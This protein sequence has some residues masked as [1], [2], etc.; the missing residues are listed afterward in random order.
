MEGETT[1]SVK[2]TVFSFTG[3]NPQEW[4][5]ATF[6]IL[7]GTSPQQFRAVVTECPFPDYIGKTSLGIFAI[8]GDRLSFVANEPGVAKAPKGFEGD[9]SSRYFVFWRVKPE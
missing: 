3:V 4:Y 5:R 9:T 7:P 6:E 2:G 1:I 8:N